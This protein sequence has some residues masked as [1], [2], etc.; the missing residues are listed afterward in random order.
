MKRFGVSLPDELLEKFDLSI[1]EKGYANRSEAL[2]DLIRDSLLKDQI[3]SD[4]IVA[5]TLTLV[6]DHH[7]PDLSRKLDEIQH[8]HHGS[9]LSKLHI[10]LDHHNCLEVAVLKGKCSEIRKLADLMVAL[11][12]VKHG[13]LTFT[14]TGN[15]SHQ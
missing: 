4:A 2:R 9:V 1:K 14:L 8:N 15:D 11:R 3:N 10:H 7:T 6:F 5:G 13:K 12:G